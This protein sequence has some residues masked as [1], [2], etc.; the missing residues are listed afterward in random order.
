[1]L[2]QLPEPL[3]EALGVIVDFKIARS[4]LE[5]VELEFLL[6]NMLCYLI[7]DVHRAAIPCCKLKFA[8]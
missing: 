1:M 2:H 7:Q 4:L 5:L 3:L 8:I 6:S